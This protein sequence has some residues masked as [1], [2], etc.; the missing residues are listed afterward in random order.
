MDTLSVCDGDAVLVSMGRMRTDLFARL[1]DL[2][3]DGDDQE[4]QHQA[5]G[6]ADHR[7]VGLGDVVE[8]TFALL[9]WTVGKTDTIHKQYTDTIA[10]TRT[11]THTH[12]KRK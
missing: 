12:V 8:Q 9:F 4:Q 11:H 5:S 1:L 2:H 3:Q 10:Q 6:H 7:P